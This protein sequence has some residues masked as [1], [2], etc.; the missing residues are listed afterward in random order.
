MGESVIAFTD[1]DGLRLE[2]IETAF[3]DRNQTWA[4]TGVPPDAA[5]HGFHSATLSETGYERTARLLTETM[6][7]RLT[8]NAQNRFRY[9]FS[10]E[11]PA[12]TI[13]VVCAPGGAA[14]RVANGT[15]HHIAFRTP[16]D[17]EQAEWLGE[18]SR[19]G[20][21][22]SPVMDRIYFHSIYYREPG[23]ILFEIA[24][25]PPGFTLDEPLEQ[26]GRKL[27]LPPWFESHRRE[28]E[29]SL[30]EIAISRKRTWSESNI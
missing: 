27:K 26:L 25:D 22:L 10:G 30:P 24:T 14:G 6:G 15:V 17:A 19:L 21:N 7:L 16:N 29:A 3:D 12:G 28:I 4:G 1:P 9:Q 13:D 2:L 23:G 20:Y 8:G 18:L 11:G 5:I